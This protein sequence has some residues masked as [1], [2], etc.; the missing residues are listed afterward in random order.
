MDSRLDPRWSPASVPPTHRRLRTLR[1]PVFMGSSVLAMAVLAATASASGGSIGPVSFTGQVSGSVK[2]SLAIK[3]QV[4]GVSIPAVGCQVQQ[5]STPED[6]LHFPSPT[7]LTVNGHKAKV[8]LMIVIEATKYGNTE[9]IATDGA[10]VTLTMAVG[11]KN[12]E[13]TSTSGT[14]EVEDKGLAGS[15]DVGL[16]P[17][18]KAPGGNPVQSGGA[19]KAVHMSGSWSTCR[20]WPTS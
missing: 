5:S 7:T 13:W 9:K 16:I 6:L 20:P 4:S 17:A 14:L 12:S 18:S 2:E 15:F 10:D 1:L 3:E 19:T 8:D 11:T